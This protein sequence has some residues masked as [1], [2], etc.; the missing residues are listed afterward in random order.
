M[1]VLLALPLP[2]PFLVTFAGPLLVTPSTKQV[3]GKGGLQHLVS[4]VRAGGPGVLYHGAAAAL[5]ASFVGH[6]PWFT[7]VSDSLLK[8]ALLNSTCD[9]LSWQQH[10]NACIP[11]QHWLQCARCSGTW[12]PVCLSVASAAT[13]VSFLC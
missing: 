6:F 5:T 12:W 8:A 3:E 4:K 9:G 11:A 10:C 1:Y 7:T 2:L 13:S